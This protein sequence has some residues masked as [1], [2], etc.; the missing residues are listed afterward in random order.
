MTLEQEKQWREEFEKFHKEYFNDSESFIYGEYEEPVYNTGGLQES[1]L[2][3]LEARKKAQEEMEE[4][5]QDRDRI[6]AH[7]AKLIEE[8]TQLKSQLK[9]ARDEINNLAY[10]LCQERSVTD[11]VL[12]IVGVPTCEE[13]Y[14]LIDDARDIKN[15]RKISLQVEVTNNQYEIH[16]NGGVV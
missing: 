2:H 1:W 9:N 11:E 15:D 13:W 7:R 6:H 16:V 8:M 12:D 10:E 3:Y 5:T 14:S 4:M